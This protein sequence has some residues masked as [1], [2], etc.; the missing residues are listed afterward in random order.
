MYQKTMLRVEILEILD[1]VHDGP[2]LNVNVNVQA[3]Y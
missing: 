1:T 3:L 2:L